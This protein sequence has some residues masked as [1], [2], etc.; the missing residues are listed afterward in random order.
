M[1]VS[2]RQLAPRHSRLRQNYAAALCND[3]GGAT[4][5]DIRKAV[6]TLEDT[7]RTARRVLGGAH[8][9]ARLI[10]TSLRYARDTLRARETRSV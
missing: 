6:T 5:D 4:L 2:Y 1:L 8:P 7:E 3:P 9:T 10:E